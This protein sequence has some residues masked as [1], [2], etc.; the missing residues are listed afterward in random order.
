MPKRN[1]LRLVI[2]PSP[3]EVLRKCRTVIVGKVPR[4]PWGGSPVQ[5]ADGGQE[6]PMCVTN[7]GKLLNHGFQ[8]RAPRKPGERCQRGK[9][10]SGTRRAPAAAPER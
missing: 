5:A 9:P 6:V 4:K 8:S 2:E 10:V 7:I 3:K 1:G